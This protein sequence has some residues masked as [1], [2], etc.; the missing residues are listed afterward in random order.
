[1]HDELIQLLPALR[2]F[3]FSLTGSRDDA[4]DLLQATVERLL[5]RG[6]PEDAVLAKWAFRVC[7]NLWIDDYRARKVRQSASEDPSLSE[8]QIVDGE[9]QIHGELRLREVNRA[10]E[11]LNDEQRSVLSLVVVEGFSYKQVAETLNIPAGTVMSRLARA[12]SA[13]GNLLQ[14]AKART[15]A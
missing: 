11:Q 8:H 12:R 13:L 2:R 3:A 10:M 15:L 1:M 5:E 4:D 9:R 7:R 6:L 14:P